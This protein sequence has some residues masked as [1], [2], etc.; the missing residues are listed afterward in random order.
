MTPLHRLLPIALLLLTGQSV[1]AQ[2]PTPA[3]P[4]PEVMWDPEFGQ[5]LDTAHIGQAYADH[6]RVF[7]P[8]DSSYN[9]GGDP[10]T[11]NVIGF[12]VDSVT[13][14]P[15][16]FVAAPD[17][18]E[19]LFAGGFPACIGISATDVQ[20]P[21]GTYSIV[22]YFRAEVDFGTSTYFDFQHLIRLIVASPEAV[23]GAT[24][25]DWE[26]WTSENILHLRDHVGQTLRI[27]AT[28]LSGRILTLFTKEK[29]AGTLSIE[30][31]ASCLI[32]ITDDHGRTRR[33]M[34]H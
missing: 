9:L 12:W 28:D 5:Y 8:A 29:D 6:L 30:M 7:V 31:P 33:L 25:E 18:A 10:V 3:L 20:V 19:G 24:R 1:I 2:C 27:S 16:G 21:S 4:G 14:L 22:V 17:P 32:T 26:A 13:G 15:P 23:N 34:V 11:V